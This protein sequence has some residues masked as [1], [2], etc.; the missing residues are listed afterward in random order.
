[1]K[2][3]LTRIPEYIVYKDVNIEQLFTIIYNL[4]RIGY[5]QEIDFN[6]PPG[7]HSYRWVN[8]DHTHYLSGFSDDFLH[9]KNYEFV[10]YQMNRLLGFTFLIMKALN[11]NIIK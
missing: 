1:M 6:R 10:F 4:F 3:F 7:W 8:L 2:D 5:V 9:S 11:F